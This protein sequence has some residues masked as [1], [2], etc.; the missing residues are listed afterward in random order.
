[1]QL[2]DAMGLDLLLP[3]PLPALCPPASEGSHPCRFATGVLLAAAV[4]VAA[5]VAH[6]SA[7][8]DPG[9]VAAHLHGRQ[10]FRLPHNMTARHLHSMIPL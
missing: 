2:A 3:G 6:Q 5:A 8:G 7:A 4:A 1:M 9:A 10:P